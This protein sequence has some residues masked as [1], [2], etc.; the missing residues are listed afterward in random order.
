MKRIRASNSLAATKTATAVD[1]NFIWKSWPWLSAAGMCA[2]LAGVD[3]LCND[4]EGMARLGTTVARMTSG[5]VSTL[6]AALFF[7]TVWIVSSLRIHRLRALWR[8]GL[9]LK[10]MR[11]ISGRLAAGE[12]KARAATGGFVGGAGASGFSRSAPHG[13]IGRRKVAPEP[14]VGGARPLLDN[15]RGRS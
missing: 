14:E 9:G 6:H 1:M 13:R 7:A 11:G 3:A 15:F 2:A 4:G 8:V 12:P 10:T 5:E